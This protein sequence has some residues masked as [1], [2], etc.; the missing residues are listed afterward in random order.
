MQHIC[1][2]CHD[3]VDLSKKNEILAPCDCRGSMAYIHKQ[4]FCDL[5][6]SE[7]PT[8]GFSYT[9]E[10]DHFTYE[11]QC[12]IDECMSLIPKNYFTKNIKIRLQNDVKIDYKFELLKSDK[13]SALI[14]H[15]IYCY[16]GKQPLVLSEDEFDL[17]K[18]SPIILTITSKYHL[19][20]IITHLEIFNLYY[21]QTMKV[22]TYADVY[23]K[24]GSIGF[25]LFPYIV[26]IYKSIPEV[27]YVLRDQFVHLNYTTTIKH[28]PETDMKNKY[29]LGF[30]CVASKVAIP[31][32]RQM[33]ADI[34]CVTYMITVVT[35]ILSTLWSIPYFIAVK[36]FLLLKN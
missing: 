4:C 3:T 34:D 33:V 14:T 32:N 5:N 30:L 9:S 28:Y 36:L 12:L 2:L 18:D 27:L 11:Q 19:Q 26:N 31:T 24:I 20:H 7:C 29:P 35:S 16:D 1:W 21:P 23:D 6:K 22:D 17:L 25:G 13:R 8:C 15:F 10:L